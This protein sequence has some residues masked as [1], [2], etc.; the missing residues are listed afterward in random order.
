MRATARP[1]IRFAPST[2]VQAEGPFARRAQT[3]L[4]L[5]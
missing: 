1:M 2:R 5:E 3:D 4:V